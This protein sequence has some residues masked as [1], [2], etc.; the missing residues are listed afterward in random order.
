MKTYTVSNDGTWLLR[1]IVRTIRE[2][3][4]YDM[5]EQ[6]TSDGRTMRT[7]TY[8]G[9]DTGRRIYA[10]TTQQCMVHDSELIDDLLVPAEDRM[11]VSAW[12]SRQEPLAIL[13][14]PPL[15]WGV[16]AI[17][18]RL[19]ASVQPKTTYP[20][21]TRKPPVVRETFFPAQAPR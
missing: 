2:W 20:I 5:T 3:S 1:K 4:V 13:D 21:H 6:L 18:K 14:Q 11:P 15:H 8:I 19:K 16:Q 17:A 9:I 10:L 12:A 7:W